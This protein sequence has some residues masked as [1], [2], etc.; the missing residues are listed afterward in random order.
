MIVTLEGPG[1]LNDETEEEVDESGAIRLHYI[2]NLAAVG[3][4]T[5]LLE[6]E[7]EKAYIDKEIY[8]QVM[9]RVKVL[10]RFYFIGGEIKAGGRYPIVGEITLSQ[11]IIAAG[12]FTEWANP[13]KI[14][15]VRNN[16][17]RSIDFR[18]IR[19][20]PEKDVPLKAGD[21]ITVSRGLM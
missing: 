18:K 14:I 19:T 13:K 7:I 20:D 17:K 10:N 9:A 16:S 12:N 4:T 15:L 11:A 21:S 6:R 2:G 8:R 1:G 5:T 3:K